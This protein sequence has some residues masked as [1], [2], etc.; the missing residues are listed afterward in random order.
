MIK[1]VL[2]ATVGAARNAVAIDAATGQLLWMHHLAEGRRGAAS[3]R[4]M[5][6]RGVGYWT[7]GR[8]DERIFYVTP[9]FHVATGPGCQFEPLIAGLPVYQVRL[10]TRAPVS[11]YDGPPAPDARE[12]LL[13][14]LRQAFATARLS[15]SLCLVDHPGW[16][17]FVAAMP[18]A[19]MSSPAASRAAASKSPRVS[20]PSPMISTLRLVPGGNIA[21]AYSSAAA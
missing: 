9:G 3:V 10:H 6:G 19:R 17:D 7:D 16:I 12:H 18:R 1:G 13:A 14:G 15:T 2:Y 8:G 20:C 11:I 21:S 5:S 4:K